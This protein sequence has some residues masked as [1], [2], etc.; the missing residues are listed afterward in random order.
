MRDYKDL[1]FEKTTGDVRDFA[2]EFHYK[3]TRY[4]QGYPLSFGELIGKNYLSEDYKYTL[5]DYFKLMILNNGLM[6]FYPDLRSVLDLAVITKK[7]NNHTVN[8]IDP[9]LNAY[10][11]LGNKL[12]SELFNYPPAPIIIPLSNNE[13]K[14][15]GQLQKSILGLEHGKRVPVSLY[16]FHSI[17]NSGSVRRKL[18]L[19]KNLLLLIIRPNADD[20]SAINLSNYNFYYFTKPFR[21]ILKGLR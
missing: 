9:V 3:T 6:D 8:E 13:I 19:I 5:T 4:F 15:C 1:L 18:V 11:N 2:F 14:F 20:L 12:S 16:F 7:R 10:M 21:L 17:K